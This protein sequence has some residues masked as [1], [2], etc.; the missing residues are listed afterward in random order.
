MP[1]SILMPALSPTMT[2]GNLARWL[3]Q[4]GDSVAPGDVIAEIETDKATM[5]VEAV[6]EGTLGK[7]LVAEG[8]EEVPVNTPIAVLLED[9]EDASALDGFDTGSPDAAAH[10][11]AAEEAP[12]PA[13]IPKA[14]E[15]SVAQSPAATPAKPATG[16]RVFATPLARRLAKQQGIDI[17]SVAGSG[18]HGRIVKADIE[19]FADGGAR[20]GAASQSAPVVFAA[21]GE[22]EYE[23][24]K[25]SNMRKVI[26][27]RMTE[28][29]QQVPHF[30]LTVDCEIDKLLEAR[31][32]LNARAKD[33]EFKVSV[34]DM[35]IK[36]SAATLMEVPRANAG[37]SDEGIRLYKQADIA[38]AVAIEDGL[39]T[40]IVRRAEGKGMRRISE[41]MGDLAAR[42]REGKLMPEEYQGGTFTISNL[43]MFGVKH[44]EAV[45]NQPQGAI[46]AVGAGE[47]RPV[48]KDGELAV[49]TVM[50]LTLSVDHR[51]LDGAIGAQFLSVL[52]GLIENPMGMLL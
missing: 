51:A 5:E 21:D 25:P 44:F 20:S 28:S 30:Y 24:I 17:A 9:G 34:N 45:I 19:A 13:A 36:A 52:K 39:V 41:E 8:A 4:E 16:D 46:L 11:V 49:A 31:K 3:K 7:I 37:W 12:E 40:P 42:A 33:G 32:E 15:S 10:P 48:V 43:G 38:V 1:I 14:P 18:P 47:Q 26:A 6:D 23:I 50:S 22:A 35:V 27:T 29:K 2:E